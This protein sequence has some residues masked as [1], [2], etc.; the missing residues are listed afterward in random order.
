VKTSIQEQIRESLLKKKRRN[1]K[2]EQDKQKKEQ[3]NW[4]REPRR[5]SSNWRHYAFLTG[6]SNLFYAL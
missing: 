2:K 3:N 4:E 5:V 1:T 6:V